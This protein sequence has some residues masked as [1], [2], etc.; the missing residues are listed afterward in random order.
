MEPQSLLGIKDPQL[1]SRE[2]VLAVHDMAVCCHPEGFTWNDLSPATEDPTPVSRGTVGSK[3][4]DSEQRP[5]TH[6]GPR[7]AQ[8]HLAR[9]SFQHHKP[10]RSDKTR[11]QLQTSLR[12][13]FRRPTCINLRWFADHQSATR[14]Q[15]GT[16]NFSHQWRDTE[17]SGHDSVETSSGVRIASDFRCFR[18][19]HGHT[20]TESQGPNGPIEKLASS[21]RTVHEDDERLGPVGS[22]DEAGDAAPRTQV[23]PPLPRSWRR[24]KAMGLTMS[25]MGLDG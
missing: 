8:R 3:P 19:D 20:R 5:P 9:E 21:C 18:A 12:D 11:T 23:T 2:T 24:G 6:A 16:R 22:N 1:V 25:D 17:G 15:Q 7:S 10:R 4:G 13:P 14:F